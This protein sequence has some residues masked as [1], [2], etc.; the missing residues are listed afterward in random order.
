MSAAPIDVAA[1]D[2]LPDGE[3][4][5]VTVDETGVALIRQG[6]EV[7]AIHDT[8]SHALESLSGGWI[9]EGRIECPRH[10]AAF[11]L[12]DGAALTP[13]ATRA[14][15]TFPVEVRDGRVLVTP[16]PSCPHP[17]LDR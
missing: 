3:A 13:P 10:G 15:P 4:R 2:E 12:S 6:K 16:T 14:V 1:L 11:R 17:I 7:F 9:D 5:L 8:C